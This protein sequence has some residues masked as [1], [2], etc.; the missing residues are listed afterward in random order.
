MTI[1]W[2][3]LCSQV[4]LLVFFSAFLRFCYENINIVPFDFIKIFK[5][6][7]YLFTWQESRME[8]TMTVEEGELAV[9]EESLK[10]VVTPS[11]QVIDLLAR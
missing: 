1:K 5:H 8:T 7:G 10:R 11:L 6:F 3:S 9:K 2:S 4:L